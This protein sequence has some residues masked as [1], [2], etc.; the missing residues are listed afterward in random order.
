MSESRTERLEIVNEDE[1]GV[2]LLWNVGTVTEDMMFFGQPR[3][4]YRVSA[5]SKNCTSFLSGINEASGRKPSACTS[6]TSLARNLIR[7]AQNRK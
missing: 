1:G 4:M 7:N 3:Y 2:C 5:R 6:Q